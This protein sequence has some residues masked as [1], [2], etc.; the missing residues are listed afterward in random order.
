MYYE[1]ESSIAETIERLENL[2]IPESNKAEMLWVYKG[3]IPV[4]DI[5]IEKI[6]ENSETMDILKTLDLKST[7][8]KDRLFY[9]KDQELLKNMI[10]AQIRQDKKLMGMLYGY[11]ECCVFR[12]ST[13]E[14]PEEYN[15][16]RLLT[17]IRE[18]Q[19]LP[20]FLRHYIPCPNCAGHENT[21]S[22]KLDDLLKRTLKHSSPKI[23]HS[24]IASSEDSLDCIYD[25]HGKL[26]GIIT[27]D[28]IG[29]PSHKL[30]SVVS[31]SNLMKFILSYKGSGP[32]TIRIKPYHA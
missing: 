8:F 16:N 19:R 14:S 12:Y 32:L 17:A 30:E 26:C 18:G 13:L 6:D 24:L 3:N 11:P 22:E 15:T 2:G 4:E 28:G 10:D 9:S 21:P 1:S 29:L 27:G 7:E 31:D 25:A 5:Y 23:Y 20:R